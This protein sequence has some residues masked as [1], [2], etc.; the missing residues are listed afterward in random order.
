MGNGGRDNNWSRSW[1]G[2]TQQQHQ[3][4]GR[5]AYGRTYSRATGANETP[6]G[7]PVRMSPVAEVIP[8]PIPA[9]AVPDIAA[10]ALK[11]QEE[12]RPNKKRKLDEITG[13]SQLGM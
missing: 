11:A 9:P 13:V 12:A 4:G 5:P 10:A 8:A 1:G 7:T 3:G 6:L 2:G